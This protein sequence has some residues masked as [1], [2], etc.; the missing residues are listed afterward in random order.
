MSDLRFDACFLNPN[1]RDQMMENTPKQISAETRKEVNEQYIKELTT[2][3]VP[4]LDKMSKEPQD[5][6]IEF[7]SQA[8]GWIQREDIT[9]KM[10]QDRLRQV[11]DIQLGTGADGEEC[12]ELGGRIDE[13]VKEAL[14][15]TVLHFTMKAQQQLSDLFGK[16]KPGNFTIATGGGF[17]NPDGSWTE[18]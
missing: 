11:F 5:S 17:R 13:M 1:L 12:G 16:S 9:D 14:E 8:T 3:L 7:V 10:I 2:R 18:F 4:L 15:E 6:F